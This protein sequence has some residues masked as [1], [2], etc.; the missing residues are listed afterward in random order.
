[1]HDYTRNNLIT[2]IRLL[3]LTL[4]TTL[5][6]LFFT[7]SRPSCNWKRWMSKYLS[8]KPVLIGWSMITC[9]NFTVK[10]NGIGWSSSLESLIYYSFAAKS[11]YLQLS[12]KKDITMSD[13]S[14]LPL[15]I[16]LDFIIWNT[17]LNYEVAC[18]DTGCYPFYYRST[19]PGSVGI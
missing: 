16:K 15:H 17:L 3:Q 9:S 7:I 10:C 18:K 5:I 19:L 4:N 2:E 11:P 1:M 8:I 13:I 14:F 12:V 6:I